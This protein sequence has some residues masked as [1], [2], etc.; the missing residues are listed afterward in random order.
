MGIKYPYKDYKNEKDNMNTGNKLEN[1]SLTEN[2]NRPL[3]FMNPFCVPSQDEI[4]SIIQKL[5]RLTKTQ[6]NVLSLIVEGLSNK[7]IAK[8]LC[9]QEGTI[10]MHCASIFKQLEVNNRTQAA[11]LSLI[12]LLKH[13]E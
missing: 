9:V 10:K 4:K 8:K 6:K 12:V 13:E 2:F 1:S 3:Q 7:E 5:H 11:L